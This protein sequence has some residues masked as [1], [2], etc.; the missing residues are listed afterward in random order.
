MLTLGP[1]GAPKVTPTSDPELNPV[2]N[3]SAIQGDRVTG[4]LGARALPTT[5]PRDN[6][7]HPRRPCWPQEGG[8][9]PSSTW[10]RV[11]PPAPAATGHGTKPRLCESSD[12]PGECGRSQALPLPSSPPPAGPQRS[13]QTSPGASMCGRTP[14][15]PIRLPPPSVSSL[16]GHRTGE[17][18]TASPTPP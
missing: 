4:F 18:T 2:C 13:C 10:H 3:P 14:Q 11:G 9:C 8:A 6:T 15:T 5:L 1:S 7:L 12:S 17:M 16:P